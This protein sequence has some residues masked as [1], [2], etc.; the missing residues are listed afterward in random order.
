MAPLARVMENVVASAKQ[1]AVRVLM[2]LTMDHLPLNHVLQI[3]VRRNSVKLFARLSTHNVPLVFRRR[4]RL[5]IRR[6]R[7]T[8]LTRPLQ[9]Q[10]PL[11][12]IKHGDHG[13][14]LPKRLDV[15]SWRPSSSI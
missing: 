1:Q 8:P 4:R 2:S 15:L 13:G 3:L 6:D 12:K 10:I 7:L 5:Q 9:I 14:D 11:T